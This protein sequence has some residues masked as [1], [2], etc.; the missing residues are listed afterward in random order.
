MNPNL[1]G[2][3]DW[4]LCLALAA[5][6]AV[7]AWRMRMPRGAAALLVAATLLRGIVALSPF[8]RP[9]DLL[10]HAHNLMAF[11]ATGTVTHGT[12]AAGSGADRALVRIPYSALLYTV[13]APFVPDAVPR[14]LRGASPPRIALR[15]A[16]LLLEAMAPV[17]VFVIGLGLWPASRSAAAWAAAVLASMPEGTLVLVKGIATN[18][19][20]NTLTLGLLAALAW[21]KPWPVVVLATAAA[22]GSHPGNALATATLLFA[23]ALVDARVHGGVALRYA[24]L[25]L[26][27]GAVLAW[28][29]FYQPVVTFV[30]SSL[31][32]VSQLPAQD[33]SFWSVR[34]V[35]LWK[36]GSNLLLKFGLVPVVLALVALRR[37]EARAGSDLL[38]CW[39]AV[40]AGYGLVAVVTPF[41]LR[42]EYF[43]AP[44]LALAAGLAIARWS[45]DG[46]SRLRWL[47]L[48]VPTAVQLLIAYAALTGGFQPI[49]VIIPSERYPFPFSF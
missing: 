34:W 39:L 10:Y 14:G 28:L 9:I 18:A 43:A 48:A 17:L 19:L 24:R 26:V 29:A 20:G 44:A 35:H 32:T 15:R 40:A 13:L 1:L 49:A 11:Q 47:W 21:R 16:T 37:R 38:P 23:W 31:G 8:N 33:A 6:M 12:Y 30:V 22:L 3:G 5:A 41:A 25:P 45:T 2:R 27:A 7:L 36:V 42:F 4:P 46:G